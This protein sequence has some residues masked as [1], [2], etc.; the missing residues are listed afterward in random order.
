MSRLNKVMTKK[1]FF[2]FFRNKFILTILIFIVWIFLFDS[3]NILDRMKDLKQL[4]ELKREK[5]YYKERI[6]TD[7][8]KLNELKTNNENLEKFA[9]EQYLMKKDDEDIFIVIDQSK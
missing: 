3:N 7:S 9:R 6:K 5:V 4:R 2:N 1:G 8:L